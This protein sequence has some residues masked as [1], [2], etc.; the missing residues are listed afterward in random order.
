[1]GIQANG[2]TYM[3]A[4]YKMAVQQ[5][6]SIAT[7]SDDGYDNRIIFLTD[8]IYIQWLKNE[9]MKRMDDEFDCMVTPMI[10]NLKLDVKS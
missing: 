8:V 4:G 5:Y 9:L 10:F 7:K 3:E 6:K 1:M 2:G